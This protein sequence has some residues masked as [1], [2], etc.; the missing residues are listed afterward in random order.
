[1]MPG[2]PASPAPTLNCIPHSSGKS[3][4][5]LL[6]PGQPQFTA[7]AFAD[8]KANAQSN[9]DALSYRLLSK[10]VYI[11]CEDVNRTTRLLQ[12]QVSDHE[13]KSKLYVVPRRPWNFW[14]SAD[15][16][17]DVL[18]KFPR[19]CVSM[20]AIPLVWRADPVSGQQGAQNCSESEG[21]I[22]ELRGQLPLVQL[23]P[24]SSTGLSSIR[25]PASKVSLALRTGGSLVTYF[26]IFHLRSC[27]WPSCE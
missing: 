14:W 19:K 24:S 11:Y 27:W 7:V 22:L 2:Y 26:S 1:M 18:A 23:S 20:I 3:C 5:A 17:S 25:V 10:D 4:A 6:L 12:G 13:S 21:N 9:D 15:V 16:I 8:G